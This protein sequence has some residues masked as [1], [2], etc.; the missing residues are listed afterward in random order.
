VNL[1][2]KIN[3]ITGLSEL[4]CFLTD[5]I[6]IPESQICAM[7]NWGLVTFRESRLLLQEGE[8]SIDNFQRLI[9]LIAHELAHM[10]FG[11]LGTSHIICAKLV[12]YFIYILLIILKLYLIV[13][14]HH[15]LVE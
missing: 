1:C 8:Y 11:N 4:I 2:L 6:G 14:S 3:Y 9:E 12:I 15:I 5:I 13:F 10:W 7:E